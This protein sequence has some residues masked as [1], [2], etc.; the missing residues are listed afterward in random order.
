MKKMRCIIVDDE[1]VARKILREFTAQVPYLEL[2]GEFE[3][4]AKTK[5][6]LHA[7]HAECF[8]I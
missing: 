1:P 2:A 3:N 6:F 7:D 4:V 8:S 5:A